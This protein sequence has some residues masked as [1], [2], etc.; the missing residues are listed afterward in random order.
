MKNNLYFIKPKMY[1]LLNIEFDN[2]SKKLKTSQS[3]KTYLWH[4]RLGHIGLNM[5]QRLVKDGPLSFLEVE[6]IPQCESYLEGKITKRP[7][8]SKGNR[9]EGLFKLKHSDVVAP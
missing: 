6:P 4:L 1:S 8:G 2:N 9:V 3:Y 7:F 5:I